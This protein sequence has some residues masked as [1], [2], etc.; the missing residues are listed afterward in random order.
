MLSEE[1]RIRWRRRRRHARAPARRV[2]ESLSAPVIEV[3]ES[4]EVWAK[5]M[6]DTASESVRDFA[7]WARDFQEDMCMAKGITHGWDLLAHITRNAT[8]RLRL[9][10][11]FMI[12]E[13]AWRVTT[14]AFEAAGLEE[15]EAVA[16]HTD[17][18]QSLLSDP[19]L[20][21]AYLKK[22][23]EEEEARETCATA[24]LT[25]LTE[26]VAAIRRTTH[27]HTAFLRSTLS[28]WALQAGRMPPSSIPADAERRAGAAVERWCEE[29]G[30]EAEGALKLAELE[31]TRGADEREEGIRERLTESSR[32]MLWQC[33]AQQRAIAGHSC[34]GVE[35]ARRKVMRRGVVRETLAAADALASEA[36]LRLEALRRE[37]E[38]VL[39]DPGVR[40]WL[41]TM[42]K[43]TEEGLRHDPHAASQW[44]TYFE[45]RYEEGLY[46]L[47]RCT[48]VALVTAC[49]SVEKERKR[50][51]TR[52]EVVELDCV[53]EV[54]DSEDLRSVV[55]HCEYSQLMSGGSDAGGRELLKLREMK[56]EAQQRI[57]VEAEER[58]ARKKDLAT[59]VRPSAELVAA[60]RQQLVSDRRRALEAERRAEEEERA[61][62]EQRQKE[63]NAKCGLDG[64]GEKVSVK[65]MA[66]RIDAAERAATADA[67]SPPRPS[68]ESGA[69]EAA[70][71]VCNALAWNGVFD[72]RDLGLA[73]EAVLDVAPAVDRPSVHSAARK[74]RRVLEQ[75]V[76][77]VR[78][79]V[80]P[81]GGCGQLIPPAVVGLGGVYART[82]E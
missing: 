24:W 33:E 17:R 63:L 28:P 79:V 43:I 10:C 37:A 48:L 58:D 38:T 47:R 14:N 27:E 23:R 30:A 3:A 66:A 31:V 18:A 35:L 71:S 72:L 49:E 56:R 53:H 55:L 21:P 42:R 52:A 75:A 2:R 25:L 59:F 1:T 65:D 12:E 16:A 11:H 54:L 80:A 13:A 29:A 15:R 40:D 46:T 74:A 68:A 82:G 26:H 73:T 70:V 8:E 32:V 64:D 50:T 77:S 4:A 62:E 20:A 36:G 7:E 57:L 39:L 45:R 78:L 41:S 69:D 22:C 81:T 19:E 6:Y 61:K 44:L 76:Q 9:E 5:R 34:M 67:R 51:R 60:I